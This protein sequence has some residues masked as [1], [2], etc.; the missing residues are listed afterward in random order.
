MPRPQAVDSAIVGGEPD[1]VGALPDDRALFELPP[2]PAKAADATAIATMPRTLLGP[3]IARDSRASRAARQV[4]LPADPASTPG[5]IRVGDPRPRPRDHRSRHPRC[6]RA[7]ADA[8]RQ[9]WRQRR[10]AAPGRLHRHRR[11]RARCQ[12]RVRTTRTTTPE[13]ARPTPHRTRQPERRRLD[14]APGAGS[15]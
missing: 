13:G 5:L 15:Q 3:P 8:K 10:A 2:Q 6:S 14:R 7:L 9:R 12:R 4:R 1:V 11:H